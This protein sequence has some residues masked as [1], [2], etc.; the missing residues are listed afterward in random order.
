MEFKEGCGFCC[1]GLFGEEGLR[2][3]LRV[4]LT[5]LS[6]RNPNCGFNRDDYV[7]LIDF[8]L[9]SVNLWSEERLQGNFI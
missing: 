3:T 2:S 6:L 9:L 4:G 5:E 1:G 8:S 7:T